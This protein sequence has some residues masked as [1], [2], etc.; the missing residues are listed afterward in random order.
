[1]KLRQF[2]SKR[3][4]R[5]ALTQGE[6]VSLSFKEK[7]SGSVIA[8][9]STMK[10]KN[11]FFVPEKGYFIKSFR[12][13]GVKNTITEKKASWGEIASMI[14]SRKGFWLSLK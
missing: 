13:D 4:L 11:L 7:F 12:D 9:G 1:M 3:A 10:K 5:K 2:D 14:I 6:I 8:P